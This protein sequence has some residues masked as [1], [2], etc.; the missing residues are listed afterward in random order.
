MLS[1]KKNLEEEDCPS[2]ERGGGG[3]GAGCLAD[4]GARFA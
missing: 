2:D 1:A 4:A 3:V